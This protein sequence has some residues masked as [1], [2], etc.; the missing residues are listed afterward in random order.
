MTILTRL[1]SADVFPSQGVLVV[2]LRFEV[3]LALG[4]HLQLLAQTQYGL[5]RGIA[6]AG[7]GPPGEPVVCPPGHGLRGVMAVG[8]GE[9][10]EGCEGRSGVKAGKRGEYRRSLQG[11]SQRHLGCSKAASDGD[12]GIE[13]KV[14]RDRGSQS[15]AGGDITHYY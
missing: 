14:P 15:W 7:A 3:L 1:V 8:F 4:E 9:V 10:A 6:A 13:A 12:G 5:L 11:Q 2:N